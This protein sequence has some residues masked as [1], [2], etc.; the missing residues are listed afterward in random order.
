ME[1]WREMLYDEDEV[2]CCGSE[3]FFG[4]VVFFW[5]GGCCTN[6]KAREK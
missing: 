2:P 4:T 6:K 5:R 3:G 1:E